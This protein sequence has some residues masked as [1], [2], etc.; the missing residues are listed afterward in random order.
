MFTAARIQ[1][2]DRSEL[3]DC[4]RLAA[5]RDWPPEEAKW[6]LLFDVGEVYG[7]RDDAGDLAASA[8]LTRYGDRLA[9]ISMVLVATRY[10][11]QGFGSRIM[12]HLLDTAGD[13]RVSLHATDFGRPLYERL[14]FQAVQLMVNHTGAYQATGQAPVSRPAVAAD[15]P[16]I[17]ALDAEA[18]GATRTALYRRFFDFAEQVR[19]MPDGTGFAAT[20]RNLDETVI[21][22]V[23]AASP[24]AACSLIN[25]VATEVAGPVRL[26]GYH[27]ELLRWAQERG[28]TRRF[29]NQLMVWGGALP[30][31]RERLFVPMMLAL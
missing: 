1:R 20:W 29:T 25:D 28:L 8:T 18:S 6:G 11:R 22:P 12:R 26:D 17:V 16:T 27:P 2:L 14:G 15:L 24:A 23:V 13:A 5:D 10:G 3:A 9:V 4:L 19:I 7:W 21:G 30:G 31:R